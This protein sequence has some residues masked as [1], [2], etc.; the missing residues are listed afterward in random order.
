MVFIIILLSIL[1]GVL[2][3]D[4]S[5]LRK[6][7]SVLSFSYK[8][9]NRVLVKKE[10]ITPSEM[11]ISINELIGDMYQEDGNT[12]I[13]QAKSIGITIPP[14][15]NTEE[16]AQY[17]ETQELRRKRDALDKWILDETYE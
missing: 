5:K 16:L 6:H 11:D 15:M 13:K 9:I 17:I 2:F 3:Y 14:Y 7:V 4:L 1:I 8:A 10:V 12:I